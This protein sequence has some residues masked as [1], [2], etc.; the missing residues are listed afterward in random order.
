MALVAERPLSAQATGD[1]LVSARNVSKTYHGRHGSTVQALQGIDF[2][3]ASGE[4]VALLG[5]SGCGK[6][7]LL[8][9]LTGTLAR[10]TGTLTMC[11][12]NVAAPRPDIGRVFQNPVLLAWRTV[13]DNILLPLELQHGSRRGVWRA[14]AEATARNYL[15]LVGLEGFENHYPH[16]LSG[17]MQQRAAIGR[18]LIRDPAVL[19][20]DEPFGALDAMTRD[21]MN[22]E[23]LR[24]WQESRKTV[25]LV[26]HSIAEAVFLADRV[27]VMT[28]RPGQL[29]EILPVDLP[30]PRTLEM[31]NSPAFGAYVTRIRQHFAGH[32]GTAP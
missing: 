20:M 14:H 6:S 31:V 15:H 24:V 25:V 26:T 4:F 18:A 8:K 2:D 13:M 5:P 10:S 9:I 12:S 28:P 11:G 17:G 7:T 19:L 23:L 30:R 32:G 3:I 1:V 16:E 27:F 21:L 22:L 29:S